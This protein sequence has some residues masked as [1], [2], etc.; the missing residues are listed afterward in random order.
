M[1]TRHPKHKK[2]KANKAKSKSEESKQKKHKALKAEKSKLQIRIKKKHLTYLTL[3]V[4]AL[5]AI[6]LAVTL[7]PNLPIQPPAQKKASVDLFVMSMCPYGSQAVKGLVPAVKDLKEVQLNL[8][9]IANNNSDGSFSSLHGDDEVNED[10]RQVC[11]MKHYPNKWMDYVYCI[12]NRYTKTY[13]SPQTF[14]EDCAKESGIDASKIENC[15]NSD[16]GKNLLS[17]NIKKANELGIGASPTIFINNNSYSGPRDKLSFEREICSEV[18]NTIKECSSVPEAKEV[19]LI[20]LNDERC[21]DCDVTGLVSSLKT[22]FSKLKVVSLDYSSEEGKKLYE[23]LGIKYLPALI[24][25]ETVKEGEGYSR[26]VRYLQTL[27]NNKFLLRIGASFDPTKEICDNGIDDD[28][29]SL[30]DCEDPYCSEQIVCREELKNKLDL[31]VM[32]MCPYGVRAEHALKEFLD[33]V[34]DVN[35]SIHFIARENSDGSFSSLHG[36]NEV[37]EDLRQ[38]CIMKYYPKTYMNYIWCQS[39]H[40]LNGEDISKTY[41]SCLQNNSMDLLLIKKCSESSEGKDLLREN[42]KLTNALGIGASPTWL[43]NN[44]YQFSALD[45]ETIKQNFC[46]Y[47]NV[48]GCEKTLT[49]TNVPGGQC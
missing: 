38:V 37:N 3:G 39:Q 41:E 46:A 48:S 23:D 26:I 21:K 27:P 28:N 4:I 10:L 1:M 18:N 19:N 43:A 8:Y 7:K 30:V 14:W 42:L 47:N 35:L 5:I 33:N 17:E 22:L 34:K 31:F 12:A 9:F 45:S 44:K 16:E 11:V 49:K 2:S 6:I 25:D 24:F 20:V 15:A 40:Y 29:N 36:T 13:K 32:S